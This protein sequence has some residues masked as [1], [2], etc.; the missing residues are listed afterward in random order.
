MYYLYLSTSDKLVLFLANPQLLH[1]QLSWYAHS[2][3]APWIGVDIF[4]QKFLY[5]KFGKNKSTTS[6]Q[7]RTIILV[8]QV[9][10][11]FRSALRL[12]HVLLLALA[13]L[14]ILLRAKVVDDAD[15]MLFVR[16]TSEQRRCSNRVL[17]FRL[18]SLLSWCPRTILNKWP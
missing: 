5:A 6:S 13:L 17:H 9:L 18:D 8:R 7:G 15:D 14:F 2:V 10:H 11:R 4:W 1:C 16:L 12:Y 3:G